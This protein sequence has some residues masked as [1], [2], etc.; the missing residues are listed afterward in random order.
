MDNTGPTWM[1][2]TIQSRIPG[3]KARI[4]VWHR[5]RR[6]GGSESL[7]PR[8]AVDVTAGEARAVRRGV[9]VE[10]ALDRVQD[11][12]PID[13]VV[14]VPVTRLVGTDILGRE[15]PV[16]DDPEL[17]V[18]PRETVVESTVDC[19]SVCRRSSVIHP[20]RSLFPCT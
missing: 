4:E 11:P 16:E 18:A 13:H 20:T 17:L 15:D 5:F 9:V 12:R 19:S 1:I 7:L 10:H 6:H 8:P 2:Q 3:G 14:E